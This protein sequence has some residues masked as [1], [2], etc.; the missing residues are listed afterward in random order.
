MGVVPDILIFGDPTPEVLKVGVIGITLK[1]GVIPLILKNGFIK[2]IAIILASIASVF[3]C[4]TFILPLADRYL[5]F[6]VPNLWILALAVI[7]LLTP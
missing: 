6:S 1:N 2:E 7:V 3:C 4:V 5:V